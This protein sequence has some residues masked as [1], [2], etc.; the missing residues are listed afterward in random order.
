MSEPSAPKISIELLEDLSPPQEPGFLRLRRLRLKNRVGDTPTDE[1]TY[2]MVE[3]PALDA[4]VILLHTHQNE[5]CLRSSLRPPLHFRADPEPAVLW[6][7]PAGLIEP[8]EFARGEAGIR[9][10]AV[11]E[12]LE[13]AGARI[14]PSDLVPLGPPSWLSP[15]VIAERLHFFRAEVSR[16]EM[17]TPTED[18]SPVEAGGVIRWLPL[19]QALRE[20]EEGRIGD[21]KSE[22]GLRRLAAE[23][24]R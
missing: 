20:A 22:L 1:Y 5:V 21:V 15:G 14:E 11:R 17:V 18:G 10:C 2:D 23:L 12:A 6:E 19:T 4:T 8:E 7:V 3:R 9:N 13:E 16:D 24:L